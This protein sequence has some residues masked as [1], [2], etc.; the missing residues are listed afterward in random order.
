MALMLAGGC[1]SV[2]RDASDLTLEQKVGQLVFVASNGRFRNEDSPEWRELLRQVRENGVGGIIWS[3]SGP[4]EAA[5]D[6][7]RLLA[8]ARVAL[9]FSADL[10][11]GTG[12][13]FSDITSWPSAMAIGATGD[14]NLAERLGRVQ[15]T[16]ARALGIGQVYA[17]V[18]DVNVH[19]D[20]AVIN[21]RSFGEDPEE[22]G[23]FVAAFVRGVQAGGTLATAKHFPGHGDT[24]INSHL[25]L[26]VLGASRERLDR[27]E[28]APFRAAIDAGVGAVMVAHVAVPALDA[29]PAPRRAATPAEEAG[30]GE[31]VP[32]SLSPRMVEGLLRGELKFSG[33]VVADAIDMKA[34]TNHYDPGEAS[35]LALLAGVDVLLK[36]DDP[37]AVI[38][39]V[40]SAVRSGRLPRERLDAAVDRVLSAKRRWAAPPASDD[41]ISRVLDRAEHRAL[42]EEIA[43]RAVTLIRQEGGADL[44]LPRDARVLHLVVSDRIEMKDGVV[45]DGELRRRLTG[46]HETRL[47]DP[48]STEAEIPLVVE[49]GSAAD[50]V[51]ISLFLRAVTESESVTMPAVAREAL[52]RLSSES[53]APRIAV[54]F[55]SPYVLAEVPDSSTAIAAYGSQPLMQKAV[56]AALFGEAEISGRLPV[57]IPGV[58]ARGTG[59]SRAAEAASP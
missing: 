54:A 25:A 7:R 50:I 17:P 3:T 45:L 51:V 57:T 46:A 44:P 37:D 26:P 39:A 23:R 24:A 42:A 35:V 47:L 11:T 30:D 9:L 12:W 6:A 34:L 10:E 27:V 58:A 1:A 32:A 18:A 36:P 15:A 22:V 19:P 13:R 56:A 52:A 2:V 8:H 14:P 40:T 29:T 4:L 49:A 28:L 21:T 38:D 31:T 20:N 55:G 48:R 43:R 59:I 33:L 16:E 53:S 41:E 5:H